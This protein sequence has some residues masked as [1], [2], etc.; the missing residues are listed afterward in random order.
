MAHGSARLRKGRPSFHL[1]TVAGVASA[2][3]M[4]PH[5]QEEPQTPML[6]IQSPAKGRLHTELQHL[7][8]FQVN[9]SDMTK[10]PP[11]ATGA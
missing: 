8:L 9:L 3:H 5:P 6:E 4:I 2:S 7:I 11:D 1:L 10:E